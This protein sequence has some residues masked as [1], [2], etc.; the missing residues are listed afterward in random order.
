MF[1]PRIPRGI[2]PARVNCPV[3]GRDYRRGEG[4]HAACSIVG[5]ERWDCWGL[6]PWLPPSAPTLTLPHARRGGGDVLPSILTRLRGSTPS[7][8]T[9]GEGRDGG[10]STPRR[11]ASPIVAVLSF[12]RAGGGRSGWGHSHSST[13][14]FTDRRRLLLPPRPRGK[15]GMG[16]LPLLDDQLHRSS[17]SSPSPAP[18]GEGWDGGTYPPANFPFTSS[19]TALMSALPASFGFNTAMT[20]PMSCGPAAPADAIASATAAAISSWDSAAGM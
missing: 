1:R 16:A 18:A 11:S 19:D 6:L 3:L 20:L 14:S 2:R 4:M 5:G 7:P 8:A 17:P 15:V 13:I 9:A 12:P 10:A